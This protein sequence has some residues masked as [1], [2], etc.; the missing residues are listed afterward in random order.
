MRRRL[1]WWWLL[2]WWLVMSMGSVLAQT[3]PAPPPQDEELFLE[4]S[5]N[6]ESTGLVLRFTR[7]KSSG[8]RSSVQNLRDLEL[9]PKLFGVE[10]Q[11]EFDLDQVKGLSYT[12]DPARQALALRVDDVLRAPVSVSA[13]TVRKP[14]HGD[15]G[16]GD[17]LRRLHPAG[18]EPQHL[19]QPRVTLL[20]HQRRL[21]QHRR[22]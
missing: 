2:T 10:G 12:Y 8:L 21:E 17:Q 9:D 1:A 22:I 16:R 14:G 20:Q 5:L 13:R 15:A 18:P 7:G 6:G 4:V 11:D 3:V 19:G